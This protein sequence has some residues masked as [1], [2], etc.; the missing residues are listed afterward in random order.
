[1]PVKTIDKSQAWATSEKRRLDGRMAVQASSIARLSQAYS[2]VLTGALRSSTRVARN[3]PLKYE[4]SANTPYARR[5]HFENRKNPGSK[6][7]LQKAGDQIAKSFGGG[8]K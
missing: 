2:P 5:R 3:Q 4:V 8:L 7:Y 6:L 1:M